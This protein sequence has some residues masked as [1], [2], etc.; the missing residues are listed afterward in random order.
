M[1]LNAFST[2][3]NNTGKDNTNSVTI[4]SC[5]LILSVF[6][7]RSKYLGKLQIEMANL[8]VIDLGYEI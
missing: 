8:S 7:A 2:L 5:Y 4:V 3:E 6:I 1:G